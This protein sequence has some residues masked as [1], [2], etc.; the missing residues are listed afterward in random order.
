ME[1][2]TALVIGQLAAYVRELT[3]RLDPAAGWYGEFLRRDPEGMR[4]CLDGVAMP[5]WD[6]L[7][8]LLGDL[9]GDPGDTAREAV[10]AAGLRAAAVAAWDA[11]PGGDR[12]LRTLLDAAAGERAAAEAALRG[13]T[14]RLD[15]AADP[16]EAAALSRE[17][18]WTRDDAARAAARQADLTARLRAL[19]HPLPAVPS[20]RRPHDQPPPA[21]PT[22]QTPLPAA[23]GAWAQPVR[24]GVGDLFSGSGEPGIG[25]PLPGAGGGPGPG[26]REPGAGAGGVRGSAG[27]AGPGPAAAERTPV[28]R[29]EGRWL[30]G[31]R[32]SGG[33]R[34]AGRPQP[35]ADRPGA[36][37]P[38][39]DRPG[40]APVP[41]APLPPP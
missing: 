40:S 32:R 28:G 17:L 8:S 4:A 10:Y 16:E 36:D 6:V 21:E 30:R 19:P 34:Y 25:D 31:A 18:A 20:Q 35:G 7:E 9:P 39:A 5:P 29:A 38:G 26:G 3:R 11:V 2:P 33:A 23:D 12:E 41:E 15:A 24:S 27:P 13:L 1:T 37:R 22:S 14:R